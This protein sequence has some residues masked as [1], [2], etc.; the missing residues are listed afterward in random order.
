[1]TAVL[2]IAV[3]ATGAVAWRNW[4]QFQPYWA[5][6][7]PYLQRWLPSAHA[8]Q[9]QGKAAPPPV[10]VS[11][12]PVAK[13]PMPVRMETIGTVQPIATVN[14]KSRIDGQIVQV[15]IREGQEV[16]AGDLVFSLDSRAIEAQLRQTEAGVVRDRALLAQARRDVERLDALAAK[17]YA[18]RATLDTTRANAQALEASVKGGEASI[19]NMRV[20]LTYYAIRS[21]IDGRAGAIPLKVGN[22]VKANDTVTM[23]TINQMRPIY[24]AFAVPQREL[25]EIRRA[26]AEGTVTV[27]AAVPGDAR[28]AAS[29]QVT[30]IDNAVDA[31]TGT[32]GLKATF[33]ND[34][35]RLWPG[36]FVNVS[37]TLR[38]ENEAVVV[39]STAVQLGQDGNFAF[40]V[41]PDGSAEYRRVTVSR[42]VG[43]ETVISGGL[44]PGEP[45]VT[46]G[47][48]RLTKG[49]KVIV[50][51][52]TKPGATS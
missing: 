30:F 44:Q 21:P 19:D 32:I 6:L 9:P 2:L 29:G 18:S 7:E 15:H 35:D 4:A 39:P 47:A 43:A 10:A 11:V 1:M 36:Q 26:M 46:E 14:V 3:A 27:T 25:A 51:K 52:P 42:T 28:A 33:P 34:E 16:K 12:M 17:E 48:Y 23:L 20:Q 50:G 5:E 40:V 8:S 13:K 45:V 24:V 41:T 37:M 49:T 31:A 38:V 22:L